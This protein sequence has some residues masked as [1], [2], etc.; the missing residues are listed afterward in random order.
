MFKNPFVYLILGLVLLL[1]AWSW[2]LFNTEY[3]T[4]HTYYAELVQS[5]LEKEVEELEYEMIGIS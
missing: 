3:Y 4:S 5:N 1:G 2:Q